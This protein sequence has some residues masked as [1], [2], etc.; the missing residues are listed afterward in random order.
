[1]I[2]LFFL[3]FKPFFLQL[4][5]LFGGRLTK[6]V[7]GKLFYV[8][9]VRRSALIDNKI[10]SSFFDCVYKYLTYL[11]VCDCHRDHI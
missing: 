7:R 2:E 10:L 8:P 3:K 4:W 5:P 1:M 9:Q 11:T 6:P